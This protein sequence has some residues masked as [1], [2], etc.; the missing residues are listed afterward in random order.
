MSEFKIRPYREAGYSPYAQM[1]EQMGCK[2]NPA[3]VEA[4]MRLQYGT[5]DHLGAADFRREILIAEQLEAAEPGCLLGIAESYGLGSDYIAAQAEQA[6]GGD[7]DRDMSF[8]FKSLRRAFEAGAISLDLNVRLGSVAV[9]GIAA[10]LD[11]AKK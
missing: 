1:I 3:G 5:L 4:S 7:L 10:R 8:I 6:E 11:S 2:V 9:A